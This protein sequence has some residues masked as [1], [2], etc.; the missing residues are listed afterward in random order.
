[1]ENTLNA[2]S[3]TIVKHINELDNI[4]FY[5]MVAMYYIY[6]KINKTKYRKKIIIII[7]YLIYYD[8]NLS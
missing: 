1:M 2:I 3:K 6:I 7:I 8:I 5:Y 4:I